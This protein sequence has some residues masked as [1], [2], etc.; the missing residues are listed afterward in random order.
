MGSEVGYLI[1]I[2]FCIIFALIMFAGDHKAREEIFSKSIGG[3]KL[4]RFYI[5]CV[6]GD[7]ND[8]TIEKNIQKAQLLAE[9]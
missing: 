6:L 1:V 5:E 8:F 7:Y 9:K 2:L 3:T 4:D